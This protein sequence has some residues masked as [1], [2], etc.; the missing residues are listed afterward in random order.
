[1][2]RTAAASMRTLLTHATLID[3]VDPQPQADC[4]VLLQDGKIH[5]IFP[6][7]SAPAVGDAEVVDL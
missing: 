7:G 5:D 4:A 2:T 3:C 1:M 6:A